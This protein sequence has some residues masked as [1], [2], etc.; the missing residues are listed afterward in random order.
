MSIH[1]VLAG[2]TDRI[3]RRSEPMRSKYLA[4]SAVQRGF[5]TT[6]PHMGGRTW[7]S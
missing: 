7:A 2:V 6:A 4:V 3:R 5:E 1:P